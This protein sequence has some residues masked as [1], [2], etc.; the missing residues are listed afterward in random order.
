MRKIVVIT[1]ASSG[2][3][4][5]LAKEAVSS[6]YS[7]VLIARRVERLEQ[8]K[9]E[10]ETSRRQRANLSSGCDRPNRLICSIY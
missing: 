1:G 7:V 3:G 6:G 2:L 10:I 5:E 8:I 4:T 9:K